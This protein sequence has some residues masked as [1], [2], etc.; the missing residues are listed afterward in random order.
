MNSTLGFH[1]APASVLEQQQKQQIHR[2]RMK[3]KSR[4]RNKT[5]QRP[6]Q[7]LLPSAPPPPQKPGRKFDIRN[8]VNFTKSNGVLGSFTPRKQKQQQ[9]VDQ[10]KQ[11]AS[12]TAA[13]QKL[14]NRVQQLELTGNTR[15]DVQ[16]TM[17]VQHTSFRRE[18]G[19]VLQ[20]LTKLEISAQPELK[21]DFQG[22]KESL[23]KVTAAV[24]AVQSRVSIQATALEEVKVFEQADIAA[25]E[26]KGIVHKDEV[27]LLIYP[28]VLDT[29]KNI[30]VNIRRVF[31]NGTVKE[32]FVM[33]H[34]KANDKSFFGNFTF[35]T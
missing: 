12:S 18:M 15:A 2:A 26:A 31:D 5:L 11:H 16:Y 22:L 21:E 8:A 29:H 1:N 20:R 3:R 10:K 17:K 27:V 25:G 28:Y 32:F 35:S 23:Q 19:S 4:S 30:W 34:E 7:L 9:L 33:F 14:Y 24:Q 13:T 6:P